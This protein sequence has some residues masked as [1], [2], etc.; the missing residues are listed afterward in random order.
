MLINN[1]INL[2]Q[3]SFIFKSTACQHNYLL[4]SNK[5][6]VYIAENI[7]EASKAYETFCDLLSDD[8]VS[9]FPQE[10]FISSELVASSLTFR[11]ARMLTLHNIVE[12]NP[13]LIV[14]CTEGVT[15]QMMSKDKIKSSTIKLKVGQ[16]IPLKEFNSSFKIRRSK[17]E[18]SKKL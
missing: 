2:S 3:A 9:F 5:N 4:K 14:T 1:D 7:Y 6:I 13:R 10:E 11:L 8:L 17:N 12:N 15:K 18:S 16:E